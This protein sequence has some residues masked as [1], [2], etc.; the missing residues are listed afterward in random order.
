M[1][2]ADLR[3]LFEARAIA[4]VGASADV[5]KIGGRPLSLL[6]RHHYQGRVYAVNPKYDRIGE[7]P[8]FKSVSEIPDE[9]DVAVITVPADAVPGAVD[10]CGR[11]G[12]RVAIIFAAGFAE[13]DEEGRATQEAIVGAAHA[14]GM[15]LLGPNSIGFVSAPSRVIGSFYPRLG[16]PGPLPEGNVAMISQSGAVSLWSYHWAREQEI[17]LRHHMAL[18]NEADLDFGDFTMHTAADPSVKVIGGYVESFKSGPNLRGGRRFLD[19]ARA[20]QQRGVPICLLKVGTSEIGR[21]AAASHTGALS[22][23]DRVYDG[24]FR[25]Y[26]VTRAR[27]PQQLID[28]LQMVSRLDQLPA[29]RGVGIVSLSGGLGA[30]MVDQFVDAGLDVPKF[31]PETDA[32]LAGV[33]PRFASIEN[34]VDLT[35]AIIAEPALVGRTV[36]AVLDDPNIETVVLLMA[37]QE[38]TG[39]RIASDLAALAARTSKLLTV[40][41]CF[42]PPAAYDILAAAGIPTF[43]EPGRCCRAVISVVEAGVALGRGRDRRAV[44]SGSRSTTPPSNAASEHRAK[45]LLA[46]LGIASPRGGLAGSLTEAVELAAKI[47]GS[48]A[49]KVQAPGLAHKTDLGLVTIGVGPPDVPEAYALLIRRA[50]EAGLEVEGVLVEAMASDGLETI[51]GVVDDSAFGHVLM[52]GAGGVLVEAE[53]RVA[54][55][56]VPLDAADVD[57]MLDET[58]LGRELDGFRGGLPLDREAL[59]RAV[60][61]VSDYADKSAHW[62]RGLEINPLRVLARG[63]GVLALDALI[64]VHSDPVESG[65]LVEPAAPPDHLADLAGVST[66]A[67]ERA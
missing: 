64:E 59:T 6:A 41:W 50:L 13:V 14:Y 16:E 20:A 61:A 52:L 33:L 67:S 51:V 30:W 10:D 60:L 56:A 29:S 54:F 3:P 44:D 27:E 31:I 8:C 9:V 36:S 46:S 12:I 35:G 21:R 65:P 19:A 2:F 4:V 17:D 53:R 62:L 43:H 57:E 15:R 42:A 58:G 28:F 47:G 23:S 18:G 34:P 32:A 55:R 63:D 1:G 40:A 45:R 66:Q 25:Q 48:V 39:A 22:G 37:F 26:G 5:T 49:L 24:V 7:I 11:K 38:A